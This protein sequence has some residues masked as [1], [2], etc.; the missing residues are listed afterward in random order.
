M[1][2]IIGLGLYDEND[3]SVKGLK[4]LKACSRVYAEFYTAI[5]QGASLSAI[6]ELTGKDIDILRREEIEEERIPLVEAEKSDVAL[7]VPGDPLVATTHTEL[8][9]DA[10]RRGVETRVIH[11]SSIISAAPGLAGLQAYKFG[12]IITIPFTSENYFPTSPY[13]NIRDN[14]ERDSH[15]LVLL[16]IEAHKSRYMTANE[17]LE[18]LLR[19][20]EKLGDDTIN[21]KTLAVVIARAGS[22]RPLVRADAISSLLK[23]DFGDPLH[24]LV[25]PAGLHFIEAEY[26]VEVAGAPRSIVEWMII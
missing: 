22:E 13:V 9:L 24:C 7:L 10:R 26:L 5:L 11:A 2:Y 20:S 4:A 15:S 3:I 17:G 19:A 21:E 14:L 1:L 16:D 18:Y 8:I 25:V 12:R 6:E 23:E